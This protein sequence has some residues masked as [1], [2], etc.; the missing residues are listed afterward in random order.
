MCATISE[1]IVIGRM[2]GFLK[3]FSNLSVYWSYFL[4]YT[5]MNVGI[6]KNIKNY[7]KDQ[8][9]L[10]LWCEILNRQKIHFIRHITI[11]ISIFYICVRANLLCVMLTK[12][13]VHGYIR[14]QG[15]TFSIHNT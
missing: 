6:E 8:H 14:F 1:V 2:G 13:S 5:Y 12:S 4:C 7:H 9:K 10:S 3:S 11:K 15:T